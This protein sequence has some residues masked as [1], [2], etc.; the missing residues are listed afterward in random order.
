MGMNGSASLESEL[1]K[2]RTEVT[3]LRSVENTDVLK[4]RKM[5]SLITDN[6]ADLLAV[7]D[8]K[9]FRV[10]NNYA[11]MTTL[12]YDPV[13]LGG[14]NSFEEI[15]PDDRRMVE[16]TFHDS[17]RSG[18]GRK[19]HYRVRHRK[20]HWVE[21]ESQARVVMNEKG[22]VDC[23]VL[24]ARDIT[25]RSRKQMD[26]MRAKQGEAVCD[27][28]AT[29]GREFESLFG[30]MASE[31]EELH[32]SRRSEDDGMTKKGLVLLEESLGEARQLIRR[33][34]EFGHADEIT[35]EAI[36]M[37]ALVKHVSEGLSFRGADRVHFSVANDLPMARIQKSSVEQAMHHIM[38]SVLETDPTNDSICVRVNAVHFDFHSEARPHQLLPGDY[39]AVRFFTN[40]T[41]LSEVNRSRIFDPYFTSQQRG[42][43]VGLPTALS[44]LARNRGAVRIE[45]RASQHLVIAAYV[46][47]HTASIKRQARKTEVIPIP[48]NEDAKRILLMDDDANVRH[49]VGNMMKVMGYEVLLAKDGADAL[50]MFQKEMDEGRSID[51]V[52]M[53]LVVPSGKGGAE[54]V[55][56]LRHI[57][58]DV[59]AVAASGFI[60]ESVMEDPRPHGFDGVI[61]KPFSAKRLQEVI[62]TV[63]PVYEDSC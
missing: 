61:A 13:T 58:P 7:I 52:I 33:L 41:G 23:L 11:Y 14:T 2:L 60:H 9:G 36:S 49:F 62:N 19:I 25:E 32:E 1:E 30:N 16:R 27:F 34:L 10:W 43:E 29:V 8:P 26:L 35:T 18:V 57:Y 38:E 3:E 44:L 42:A 22:E 56:S 12:G 21:L 28:A 17:I 48:I 54:T 46:P 15:H 5:F 40:L 31:L 6:V 4:A 55:M 24:M 39:I 53:D 20:G 63:L 59:K 51:L 45:P 47:A 50:H 37:E